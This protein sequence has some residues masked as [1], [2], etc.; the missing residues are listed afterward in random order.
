MSPIRHAAVK[1]EFNLFE[2]E[3]Q[4]IRNTIER[5]RREA[6]RSNYR[7]INDCLLKG[8]STHG[9]QGLI[10]N[11]HIDAA[12]AVTN[13]NWAT[14]TGDLIEA[15][16]LAAYNTS[17]SNTGGSICPDTLLMSGTIYDLISSKPYSTS[18]FSNQSVLQAFLAKSKTITNV[19]KCNELNGA[20]SGNAN[21]FVFFNNSSEYG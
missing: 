3:N 1:I 12:T 16:L 20:L 6:L 21:G 11:K 4:S 19:V 14:K 10:S 8:D 5:K 7:R 18:G 9:L 13:T 17:L 2:L 15:D